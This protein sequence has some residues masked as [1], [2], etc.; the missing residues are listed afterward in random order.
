MI[1]KM[2]LLE[3]KEAM[4]EEASLAA[5]V[6]TAKEAFEAQMSGLTERKKTATERVAELKEKIM[7]E[8]MAEFAQTEKKQLTGG[9]KIQTRKTLQYDVDKATAWSK[10][11]GMFQVLDKKAFDKAAPGLGLDFVKTGTEDTV[12]FPKEIEV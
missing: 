9:L 7:P 1:D 11:K 6:K 10:E 3:L 12:T 4:K 8:A 2:L 5:E